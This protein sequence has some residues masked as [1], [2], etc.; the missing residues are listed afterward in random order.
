MT[1]VSNAALQAQIMDLRKRL[2]GLAAKVKTDETAIRPLL[3]NVPFLV[4]LNQMTA[5]PSSDYPIPTD[6]H[7]GNLWA[8]GERDYINNCVNAITELAE[9]LSPPGFMGT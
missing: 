9:K 3:T 1:T 7:G 2:D 4:R 5:L 8:S 6:P